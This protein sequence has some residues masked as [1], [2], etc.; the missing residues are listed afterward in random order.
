MTGTALDALLEVAR[1]PAGPPIDVDFGRTEP[2]YRELSALLSSSNGLAVFNA[3]IQ[4]FRAGDVGIGPELGRWNAGETWKD[5]Y[6]HLASELFCF[7]QDVVGVQFA[8]DGSGQVVSFD[9]ETAERSV[10][11]DSLQDWAAWLL[12]DPANNGAG[13]LATQWQDATGP[14]VATKYRGSRLMQHRCLL[15]NL[16]AR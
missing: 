16:R 7:A 4:V 9:P 6:G 15:C 5:T 14:L 1:G 8:I 10:L 12:S 13:A 11:G 2:A 3:G